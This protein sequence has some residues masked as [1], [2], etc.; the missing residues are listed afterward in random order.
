MSTSPIGDALMGKKIGEK[1]EI[2][3][4]K[5]KLKFEILGIEYRDM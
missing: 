3:V 1:V 2:D 4:P 5:G